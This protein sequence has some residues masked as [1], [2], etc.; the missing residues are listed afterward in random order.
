MDLVRTLGHIVQHKRVK[1][2][3]AHFV[4]QGKVLLTIR[5]LSLLMI[6]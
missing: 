2:G 3:F 1:A 5:T 6:I 4:L